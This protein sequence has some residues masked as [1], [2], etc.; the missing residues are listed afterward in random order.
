MFICL[1]FI[2]V[3]E[4]FSFMVFS[5]AWEK[6]YSKYKRFGFW[7]GRGCEG[8]DFNYKL[9]L[10]NRYQKFQVIILSEFGALC[11][12]VTLPILP[13]LLIFRCHKVVHNIS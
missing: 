8:V 6:A 2:F 7:G 13:K 4:F 9:N 1:G 5:R 10:Y 11:L 12:S 3:W